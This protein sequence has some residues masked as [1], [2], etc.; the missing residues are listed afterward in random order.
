M[1]SAFEVMMVLDWLLSIRCP[2]RRAKIDLCTIMVWGPCSAGRYPSNWPWLPWCCERDWYFKSNLSRPNNP[3]QPKALIN[4]KSV[5]KH[6]KTRK[7]GKR[8][9]QTQLVC[10][11][12]KFKFYSA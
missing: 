4:T 12:L 9:I 2:V 6:S 11:A 5:I 8:V 3:I 1:E 10:S 7:K